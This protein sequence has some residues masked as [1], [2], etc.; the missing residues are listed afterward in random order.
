MVKIDENLGFIEFLM[1]PVFLKN[2]MNPPPI[3]Y[4]PLARGRK[5]HRFRRARG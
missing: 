3:G 2:D 4:K 5:P 1:S